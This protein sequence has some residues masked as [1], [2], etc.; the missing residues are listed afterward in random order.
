M[1]GN[2]LIYS[3]FEIIFILRTTMLSSHQHFSSVLVLVFD[4][5]E[6]SLVQVRGS[7]PLFW[8]QPG[9][10]VGSHKVKLRAFEA[11]GPAYHR[12]M[13]RLV[14]MYGKVTVVNLLGR[15]EGERVL[16]DAFRTQHKISKLADSI[17]FIDFDYHYQMKISKDS[18]THLIKKLVPIIMS[19]A[20]FLAS[21]GSVKS[22]QTGVLRV[23]CLDCLDR[24]NSLQTA[25]GLVDFPV[26]LELAHGQKYR[27]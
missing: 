16:A 18:L 22:Q 2:F 20:V 4:E 26:C 25:I 17:E 27:G 23:N 11:S 9:V 21:D 13:S 3:K 19:N 24:T 5:G 8:E 1:L 7:V 6:C 14:S 12:H 10:Q 15:K